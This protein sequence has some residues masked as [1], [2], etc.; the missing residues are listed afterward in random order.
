MNDDIFDE[1]VC[2]II[3][4]ILFVL[5]RLVSKDEITAKEEFI[6]LLWIDGWIRFVYGV[7]YIFRSFK[8]NHW[9]F[10][11]ARREPSFNYF[12]IS[13]IYVVVVFPFIMPYEYKFRFVYC[14]ACIFI[15]DIIYNLIANMRHK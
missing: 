9:K 7:P 3:V 4:A 10:S 8:D 1:I 12:A 6:L 2:F 14:S 13:I 5:M 11:L 15:F